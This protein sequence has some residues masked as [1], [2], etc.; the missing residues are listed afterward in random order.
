MSTR[1]LIAIDQPESVRA[2]YCHHDG[3]PDGVGNILF[4]HYRDRNKVQSLIN[5]GG[6]SSLG[7]KIGPEK[8]MF[9]DRGM[10]VESVTVA[11]YRDMGHDGIVSHI[12][13]SREELADFFR[14]ANVAG[15]SMIRYIYL[16]QDGQW[17]CSDLW[18]TERW[19]LLECFIVQNIVK[20]DGVGFRASFDSASL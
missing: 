19:N 16:F 10:Q 4:K 9:D 8:P 13:P 5:L 12:L 11:Y 18:Q 3:Y 2:I 1:C 20:N 14:Q 7:A 6:L 17:H 15:K